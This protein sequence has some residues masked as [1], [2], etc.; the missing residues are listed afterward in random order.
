[1]EEVFRPATLSERAEYYQ[2]EFSLSKVKKWF[3]KN[4]MKIPQICALDAGSESGIIID[5]KLKN[6]MLYIKFSELKKKIEEY[7]P[8]DVYYD[9]NIYQNSEE[10]LKK[11]KFQN[12][13]GQELV[14]DIDLNNLPCKHKKRKDM[15][16]E[17]LKVALEEAKKLKNKLEKKFQ[18]VLI[19]YSGR[20][21]HLHVI[22]KKAFLMS[23]NE[24]RKLTKE[25]ES[26]PID[27]WVSEGYIRLIRM[28]YTLHG[29]VSR[30]CTPISKKF[31]KEKTIPKFLGK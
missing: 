10:I 12:K 3:K 30:I 8:E 28:P 2:K 6:K 1:M 11:L 20:G 15:C 27:S 17:C 22:D 7:K 19:V 14:F 4:G 18:K 5:N 26:F 29:L 21:F 31:N 24:R 25:F 16:N 13:I 23:D 9:R